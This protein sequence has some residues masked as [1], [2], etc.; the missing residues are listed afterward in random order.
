MYRALRLH[1]DCH[2]DAVSRI[3]VDVARTSPAGLALR[4]VLTGR[5]AGILLPPADV[6]QRTDALWRHTCCEVFVRPLGNRGY[7]ECNFA[8]S[9]RWAAYVF[10]GYRSGRRPA[11]AIAAPRIVTRTEDGQFAMDVT[12]AL[13]GLDGTGWCIALAVVVEDADGGISYWAL[14]HPP[15]QPD[16]HHADGFTLELTEP[17]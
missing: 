16:F 2:R 5:T 13:P 17:P 11:E 15:G 10:D 14:A 8:P 4:Y 12:L 9:T 1:P 7:Y 6:P 3:A